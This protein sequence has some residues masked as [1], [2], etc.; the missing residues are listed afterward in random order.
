MKLKNAAR[1]P[2]LKAELKH[3]IHTFKRQPLRLVKAR[4]SRVWDERGRAYYDFFSGI[5]VCSV[6]HNNVRVVRAI[7]KQAGALIHSSNYFYTPPQ[8]ELAKA[9]TARYK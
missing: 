4:D 8:N 6:G 5:A 9:L 3:F 2:Y 7:R 1:N